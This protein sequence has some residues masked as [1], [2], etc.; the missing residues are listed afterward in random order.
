MLHKYYNRKERRKREERV[1]LAAVNCLVK[2]VL[3]FFMPES[4]ICSVKKASWHYTVPV[5][6]AQL[7]EM[8]SLPILRDWS[9]NEERRERG[10]EE[11]GKKGRRKGGKEGRREEQE[12]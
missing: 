11:G 9:E 7:A 1:F 6:S 12:I 4:S 8:V 10:R 2:F 3:V 5:S